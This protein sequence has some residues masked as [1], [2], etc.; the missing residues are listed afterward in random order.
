MSTIGLVIFAIVIFAV[1][2]STHC[3]HRD[4]TSQ[5]KLPREI[6]RELDPYH[7]QQESA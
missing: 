4:K 1:C 3:A 5:R 6:Q 7:K 2:Y